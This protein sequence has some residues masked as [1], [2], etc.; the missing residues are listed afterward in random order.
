MSIVQHNEVEAGD[1]TK[2]V[3]AIMLRAAVNKKGEISDEM[4]D[5]APTEEENNVRAMILRHFI[6]GTTNMYTPRVEFNDL[7]LVMRD[8]YDKMSFNTYQPNNGE[9]WEGSPQ[10]AWRSRAL[11][12]VVRN[13]CMSIAAHATARLLFPKIFAF[14]KDSDEQQEA[15]KVMEDLMEWSGDTSNY[16]HTALLRVIEAMSSPASIGYTEYGEVMRTVKTEKVNGKWKEA[17][18]RDESYPCFKIGRAHV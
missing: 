13:K 6:L 4:S 7:S 10:S 18:V 11:R 14:N 5:Y 3:E 9:A 15:A 1:G 12:P 2:R 8:Q 16:S 17:R